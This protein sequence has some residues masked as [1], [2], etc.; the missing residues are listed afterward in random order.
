[1]APQHRLHREQSQNPQRHSSNPQIADREPRQ[2]SQH[3]VG[4]QSCRKAVHTAPWPPPDFACGPATLLRAS[5][6]RSLIPREANFWCT[7]EDSNLRTSL[8]GTDLQSVGFNHSPTCAKAFRR[9]GRSVFRQTALSPP[10]T[11]KKACGGNAASHRSISQNRETKVAYKD[12]REDHCTPEKFRMECVG[13]TCCATTNPV[14]RL[15]ENSSL[16]LFSG[17]GEGIR[18]PDPLITNQML[19]RLSYASKFRGQLRLRANQSL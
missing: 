11:P 8:G 3:C 10:Q 1:M 12:N 7:G 2:D 15:T 5:I 14:R 19:Y 9:C 4:N 6:K 18:T 16:R 13:K 17:A